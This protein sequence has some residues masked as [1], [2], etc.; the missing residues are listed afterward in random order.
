MNSE[1]Q[2]NGNVTIN[3][4]QMTVAGSREHVNMRKMGSENKSV[5]EC[6]RDQAGKRTPLITLADQDYKIYTLKWV[7]TLEK[8]SEFTQT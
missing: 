3:R 2:Q 7:L 8:T 1:R 6:N 4:H 5:F